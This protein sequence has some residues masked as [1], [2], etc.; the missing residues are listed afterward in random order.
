MSDPGNT[1][2][3]AAWEADEPQARPPD[4][5][6]QHIGRYRVERLLGQGGFGLVYLAHDDQLHRPVAIKVPHP[7]LVARPEDADAYLA[8]ARTVAGLDHPNIVPVYDVGS[9][10]D[11]PCFVVAKYIDGTDLATRLKQS[12]L[13]QHEAVELVATVA[14]ALHHAH[15]QGLVHRDIKPGNILL[16]RGG[17]PFVAD[18][19]LALREQDVGK[20]PRYAGTPA[21]M[22]PEQ[23]RGEGHRVDGRSDIFS[24]G[25]VLYELLTGRRPFRAES[26]DDLLDQITSLEPR[27]PRQIDDA[28]PRELDRICLKAL[29]KRASER[30]SAARDMAEDLRHFLAGQPASVGTNAAS[31]P[32][33]PLPSAPSGSSSGTATPPIS[34][35]KPAKVVPKGLRSFDAQDADFFLELLPGP[36][37]RDGLPDSIRFWKG[38][39][40]AKEADSTFSVGLIYGPSGCGKSSLVKAGLLPRLEKSVTAVYVEATGEETEARLLKGLRRQVPDLAG[41]LSLVESLA[42]LR[43][44]RHLEPGQ[45]VL[46]VLDQFEQWLHARRSEENTEL[47]Q[48]LR[49]CDG[50]RLQSLVMVRDD[51]WLAVSRFMQALEVRVVEGDNSRLVDL[52]DPRHARKVLTAVGRAFGALPEKELT[53]EQDAFLDQAVAGLAQDGKVISVRLALFAEMVKGKPWTPAT[54]KEVGG[55]E[56]VGV[57]FLEETFTASSAPPQHRLHQKAAQAV[58][59]AL[60]PEAGTD[61]KGT[62][63]SQQELKEASEYANRRKDFDDL[64]RILDGELRL[65]TPTDPEGKDD[66]DPSTLQAGVRYYELTHDYLVPSLRDWLTR[67]QKETRRGRAELRLADRA[68]VWNARPES[69]QLP[70]LVQWL[71]IRWH[72]RKNTWTPPQQRMMRKAGRYHALRVGLVTVLLVAAAFIGLSVREQVLDRGKAAHAAGLV[73]GLL[74]AD[75]AQVPAILG[76]LAEYRQWADPLLRE[77][78]AKATPESRQRL[79]TSLALLPMDASQVKYLKGRLLDADAGE[80]AVIRDALFSHKDELVPELWRVV[81]APQEGKKG[82]RLRAAAAL[83]KYEPGSGKWAKVEEAVGNDLVAV[84]AVYLSSWTAALRP[85]RARLLSPLSAVYRNARRRETE[86]SLAADILADYAA[87]DPQVL[88][89][90]LMD[91]DEKQFAAILAPLKG[92]GEKGLRFLT[93]ELDKELPA[94]LPSS[95]EQRE[96]LAKRQATAAVALLRMGRSGKVW[97]LLKRTPP[98]DPRVRSYLIHRLGP[99]GADAGAI[100]RRLDVEPDTTIRR[101]LLLSLGQFSEDQ[102]PTEA[103]TSLLPKLKA[104]YGNEHDPGLHAAVEWL[105]RRWDK[106]DWLKQ[107]N[108][109]WAKNEKERNRRIVIIRRLVKKE[110]TPPQWYVNGQGQTMVVIPGPVEFLMGSPATE[111]GREAVETQHKR[112][113]GRTYALAAKPV[114]VGEF[115]RFLKENK[116]EAWFD[117]GGAPPQVKRYSPEEDCPVVLVDWYRAAAYCNWLSK[118]EGMPKEQWCYQTSFWGNVTGLTAGYLRLQGYRLPSEAEWECACRAGAVTSRYYGETEELLPR[119]GWYIKNSGERTRPVGGKTPNDLGLFDLHGNVFTWCQES[120]KGA[121][122]ASLDGK[123]IAEEEDKLQKISSND[124]VLRG[125]SFNSPAVILRSAGRYWRAPANRHI[126]AGLRPARTFAP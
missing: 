40:E 88:A 50:G 12:R 35:Q 76:E 19:G 109:E 48:A 54:L 51:F 32:V 111:E 56:G 28:I 89:G 71:Q 104:M 4:G 53:G 66:A 8:E 70:S 39:I 7:R 37:D 84:P 20:G 69:R 2:R 124:C 96:K 81:E 6:P 94:D 18:F 63:R 90:L 61:I 92:Q 107:V 46:L 78:N 99:L 119:Y 49:Q 1:V 9:T 80:V 83:A 85:V 5:V 17:K 100:V 64:L 65:I 114:T 120:F 105:L 126:T 57:T 122:P 60:L 112:R 79:H 43:Q 11:F 22:S 25:V 67:K 33:P 97:P 73:Q 29:S 75:T 87:D 95:D 44:A 110:K 16:D 47:V 27:P 59:K 36:R 68:G 125:G 117:G 41:N 13:S 106:A 77:E 14:E 42:A 113:I 55:T 123:A 93:G 15:K 23:A 121:Y 102:L 86:R 34:D 21:Y 116:L 26:R 62:M 101:A 74:K 3:T 115:R 30:Y 98:D 72:T 91:A 31:A 38:R 10:E 45:K 24:L 118:K 82:Q 58:L 108:E 103:R 52:F